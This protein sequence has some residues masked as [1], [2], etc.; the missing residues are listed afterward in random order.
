MDTPTKEQIERISSF[1]R[2]GAGFAPAALAVGVTRETAL[3]WAEESVQAKEGVFYELRLAVDEARAQA[4]I[5][6]LQRIAAS[7]GAAGAKWVLEKINPEKY[8]RRKED[9][10]DSR[11]RGLGLP[12]KKLLLEI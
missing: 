9:S 6:M 4:E 5:I 7:G 3:W 12:G 10:P 2:I 11:G 8:G 1:I